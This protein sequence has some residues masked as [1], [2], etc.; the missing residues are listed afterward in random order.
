MPTK[1]A[2]QIFQKIFQKK[3]TKGLKTIASLRISLF[4]FFIKFLD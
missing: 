2:I 4:H 3:N 1:N